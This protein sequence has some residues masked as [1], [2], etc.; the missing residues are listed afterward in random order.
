M[1]GPVVHQ[2]RDAVLA[3]L[4]ALE[5]GALAVQAQNLRPGRNAASARRAAHPRRR[6]DVRRP[7]TIMSRSGIA[8]PTTSCTSRSDHS[9]SVLTGP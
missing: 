1:L 8:A 2:E 3:A 4:P 5:V 9:L 7:S 6:C